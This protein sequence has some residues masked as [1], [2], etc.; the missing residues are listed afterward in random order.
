MFVF[1]V[2]Q[3]PLPIIL[4]LNVRVF[5][6]F[7]QV[8]RLTKKADF[9]WP[10]RLVQGWWLNNLAAIFFLIPLISE[11]R[12]FI[13]DRRWLISF[14]IS[15]C[16]TIIGLTLMNRALG[17][18]LRKLKAHPKALREPVDTRA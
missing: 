5:T 3:I 9:T 11:R 13:Q 15:A 2:S 7:A 6:Q 8:R 1:L 14:A 18:E 10:R 12:I 16:L 17:E 4:F